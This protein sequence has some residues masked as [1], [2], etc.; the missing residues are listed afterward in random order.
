MYTDMNWWTKI[1][2]EVL[3]GETSKR[4]I[5]RREGIHW[6]TLKKILENSE[7]PGYR[8]ENPRPKPKIGPYLEKIAQIIEEDKHLPKKQRHTTSHGKTDISTHQ[9]DG[10]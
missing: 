9:G 6:E 1:R 8:I 2:L 4:E 3:R 5:L 7:P 10:I